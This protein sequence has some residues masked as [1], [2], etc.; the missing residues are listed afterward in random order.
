MAGKGALLALGALGVLGLLASGS[1]AATATTPAS[2]P[3][4]PPP[5]EKPRFDIQVGPAVIDKP[6]EAQIPAGWIAARPTAALAQAAKDMGR[7]GDPV[8]TRYPFTADGKKFLGV[9]TA[10][11]VVAILQPENQ[12]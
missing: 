5:D 1:K 11:G 4:P 9:V 10:P 12:L 3:P 8:G 7:L 6:A 2:P